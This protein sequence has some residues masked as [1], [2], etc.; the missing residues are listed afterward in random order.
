[1]VLEVDEL[2]NVCS[3]PPVLY[4]GVGRRRCHVAPI[5]LDHVRPGNY[6]YGGQRR[7]WNA[8]VL[9]RV[10]NTHGAIRTSVGV[11]DASEKFAE[12]ALF[13]WDYWCLPEGTSSRPGVMSIPISGGNNAW[14]GEGCCLRLCTMEH[15]FSPDR[16]LE[17]VVMNSAASTGLKSAFN[18]VEM[19]SF[20]LNASKR[21][22]SSVQGNGSVESRSYIT[23]RGSRQRASRPACTRGRPG[24]LTCLPSLRRLDLF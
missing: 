13:F 17:N 22:L 15:G 9:A 24:I 11:K 4:G 6:K 1:M 21:Y 14:R 10:W 5:F 8:S 2:H 23:A 12:Q 16:S 7:E 3:H 19:P 18:V 20:G